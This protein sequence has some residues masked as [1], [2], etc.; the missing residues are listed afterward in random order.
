MSI[1]GVAIEDK[2]LSCR[3]IYRVARSRYDT[4]PN[5]KCRFCKK[6]TAVVP[7]P[8]SSAARSRCYYLEQWTTYVICIGRMR[9]FLFFELISIFFLPLISAG[10]LTTVFA[11]VTV[12]KFNES[13]NIY[14]TR[15]ETIV[16]GKKKNIKRIAQ[17]Q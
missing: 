7:A 11:T 1:Y 9:S 14:Q 5:N 15:N 12:E 17:T 3:Y 6:P 2:K 8:T 16:Y 4:Y 10:P 13:Y